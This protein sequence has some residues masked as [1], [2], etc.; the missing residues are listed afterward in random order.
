L[1][2][3]LP[4]FAL[5]FAAACGGDDSD[6]SGAAGSG[7]AGASSGGA[8]ASAGSGGAGT[9]GSAGAAG[10]TAGG[11]GGSAGTGG[12]AGSAG[13]AAGS[14]GEGGSSGVTECNDGIDND[15]DGLVDWQRDLGCANAGDDDE[16][17]APRDQEGGFTTF[18]IGPDSQ[19]VYVSS[20]EGDDGNGG[21]APDDAVATLAR[22]AE[23]VRDGEND[24]MLLRRGDVWRGEAL[25]RFKS[26][27]DA[28]HPLVIA[29]YGASEDRPRL[30]VEKH[31]I[32]HN[33]KPRSFVAIIGLEIISYPKI[34]SDAAF[35]GETGGGFRYVGGGQGHLI[36]GCHLKHGELVVQSYGGNHYEDV[37]VRRNV[38]DLNYHVNTC[39]QNSAFRPSGM[40]ASHVTN[41]TIEGNVFDHNGWNEDVSSACAT[42][43]N[44][45]MY[46]NADGLVIRDNIIARASSMG[47]KMRSDNTGDAENLLFENNFLVDGEIGIGIGGN[48]S[49]PARFSD[50]TI[51]NNVFSQIGMGNPTERN[52]SWM[53]GVTDNAQALIEG[54]YF[55]H[56][57]WYDNAF[58]ISLG[59]GSASDIT[60]TDNLFY[61][62]R[63]RALRVK[64]KS[65]WSNVSVDGNR[66][67]DTEL[68]SCLV[69]HEGGFSDITYANNEYLGTDG[70]DWFCVDGNRRSMS[71]WE[72]DSGESGAS[73]FTGTFTDPD[74]TISTYAQSLGA[75]DSLE[76]FL[77]VA[78][79]QSRLTW[80]A[81]M[82]AGAV[83]D[84]I[85]V[86]FQ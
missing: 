69:D 73:T 39:G 85:R 24:F 72:S 18:D 30:E 3:G 21:T 35:D 70:T 10:A 32:N 40:Y 31:F 51:R 42:M 81:D 13:G 68:G 84:Y 61:G 27:K 36:E 38:I 74:R 44:H 52:F 8:G 46:L 2:A 17:A 26:G 48:T 4:F 57:P 7:G 1:L 58:G 15:G 60:V 16:A 29:S 23:L 83:N 55:L 63:R 14:A 65:A 37:E 50:V 82:T 49:E 59:G 43:Y 22:G 28:A 11:S 62:L 5:L 19:V 67:V 20:S 86:G 33:G 6:D 41:L 76:S 56:Q 9:S 78:R 47:I 34:P 71:E 53:L 54:N 64:A 12:A 45:N 77:E 75:G 79:Q 66:F 25:G 80:R